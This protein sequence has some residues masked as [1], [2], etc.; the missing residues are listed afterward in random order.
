[1]SVFSKKVRGFRLLDLI[2]V[3][4]L[5]ALILGVYLAKTM[6]GRERAE[7]ASVEREIRTERSRIRL[8][9][10]EVAHLEQPGRIERLAATYLKME[11]VPANRE[12]RADELPGLAKAG[13][14]PASKAPSAVAA[15]VDGGNHVPGV[16]PPPPPEANPVRVAQ[17]APVVATPAAGAAR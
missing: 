8:L 1:M 4:F 14:A 5:I 13:P 11:T 16:P 17:A 9:Q 3:G 10:A 7:I 15:M 12:A 6:A 2:G